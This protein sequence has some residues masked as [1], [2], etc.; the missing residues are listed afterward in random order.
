MLK[1][2]ENHDLGKIT[3]ILKKESSK[4]P[5]LFKKTSPFELLNQ[6]YMACYMFLMTLL[7]VKCIFRERSALGSDCDRARAMSVHVP[8]G[9]DRQIKTATREEEWG[10]WR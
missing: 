8:D 6:S 5:G 9:L 4:G 2:Q 10:M 3:K 1:L 7:S